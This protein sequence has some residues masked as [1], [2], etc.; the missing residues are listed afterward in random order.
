MT[1]TIKDVAKKAGV[2]IATVS[3]VIHNNSRI[4]NITRNKVLKAIKELNYHPSRSAKGLVT[5]STGNIGFVLTDDHFLKTEPFYTRIFLGTEFVTRGNEYYVLLAT[6]KTDFKDEDDLPRFILERSV[7]GIIVAGKVSDAFVKKIS[8][9]D[10]PVVFVDYFPDEGDR[11]VVMIDNVRG[12]FV[13]AQ[14]LVDLGHREIAFIG[15]D[16]TH[17]SISD[18]LAG[19]KQALEKN[20]V[21][22]NPGNIITSE[23]YPGRQNGYDSAKQLFAANKNVTAIFACNDAMAIGIMQYCSDNHINIPGDISLV[24]FDDV[25]AD[26]FLNPPLTTVRVPKI[27]LG[28]EAMNVMVSQLSSKSKNCSKK[29]LVPIELIVRQS[30]GKI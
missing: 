11:C 13:A 10:M 30:T 17:P 5:R 19:F 9:Y 6:I 1:Y 28:V 29:I 21:N 18:R 14:H 27:E 7:D 2:S 4:S 15:A 3:L 24:G 25:E 8:V 26:L 20:S 16:I 22:I 23:Q 12:G